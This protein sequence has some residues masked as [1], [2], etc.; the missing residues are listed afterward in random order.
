MFGGLTK[1]EYEILK[2]YRKIENFDEIAG[3]FLKVD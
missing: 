3:I 1:E 2:N